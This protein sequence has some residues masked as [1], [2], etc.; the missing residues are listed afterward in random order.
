MNE[1]FD[2]QEYLRPLLRWWWLLA[3]ATLVAAAASFI[4]TASQPPLYLSQ[5][6]IMVGSSIQDPNPSGGEFYLASQLAETYADI[7]NRAP[8]HNATMTALGTTWLPYYA[9]YQIGNRPVIQLQVYDVDPERGYIVAEELVRQII[10][11]GPREEQA[12]REF[13]EQQLT[14]LQDSIT[15][16]ENLIIQ[17]ETELLTIDSARELAAKQTEIRALHDKLATLQRNY[18][19]LLATTQRG[20]VNALSILEPASRPTEPVSSDLARNLLVAA[21][22]GLALAAA[23]AYLLE[24]LDKTF[25]DSEE[26]RKTL[27]LSLL[28]TVPAI[29]NV[30]EG[31]DEKLIM[32]HNDPTAAV[33]AYRMIRT[34]LQFAAVA[35]SLR[36]L[37]IT[38]A[39][40][41]DGKSLTAANISIAL[42]SAGKKVV[43]VDADLHRPTQQRLFKLYNHV[44]VTT[45]L[46]TGADDVGQLLQPTLVPGLSVLTSGPLPPNP[47]ELLGTRRMEEVLSKLQEI[48]DVVVI[49]SPPITA[50][51]DSLILAAHVDGVLMVVRAQ[52]TRRDLAQRALEALHKVQARVI[53]VVFN[54]VPGPQVDFYNRKY[55]YYQAAYGQRSQAR[56]TGRQ[57]GAPAANLAPDF[58]LVEDNPTSGADRGSA[59]TVTPGP[60]VRYEMRPQA[61][62][63]ATSGIAPSRHGA[64]GA[65]TPLTRRRPGFPLK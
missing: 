8:L 19:D 64:N 52:K 29:G 31:S 44:G 36:R 32:M 54:G 16:T 17:R 57:A 4:Y 40:I 39:E 5:A 43:L 33:E 53:G 3:A 25:R 58:D 14:K 48:A 51:V 23:G 20:R 30:Q 21:F 24:Y 49:D 61:P 1:Q 55:G 27:D 59:P 60:I 26:M 13:V 47:A 46:L 15:Q 65:S 7:A 12:R 34:N 2:L 45:A 28:G 11:L 6:T 50:V 18:A 10:L 35:H 42:A 38:S 41:K 62:D 37:L 9:V 56:P 22:A 63:L